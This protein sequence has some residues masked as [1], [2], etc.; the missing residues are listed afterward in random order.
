MR[1]ESNKWHCI[2]M[3]GRERCL[4]SAT[5][6]RQGHHVQKHARKIA[7][8]RRH[9]VRRNRGR[10]GYEC[11]C[12]RMRH[13]SNSPTSLVQV[14]AGTKGASIDMPLT[15]CVTAATT[16]SSPVTTFT[17]GASRA[18]IGVA[19]DRQG[20]G[21][22]RQSHFEVGSWHPQ[23][24]NTTRPS[25]LLQRLFQVH[26]T[27]SMPSPLSNQPTSGTPMSSTL[28]ACI[29]SHMNSKAFSMKD[30]L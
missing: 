3:H 24:V 2:S 17:A 8:R 29:C 19:P 10:D 26:L 16:S 28:T 20:S 1:R 12:R 4:P 7:A 14:E 22:L 21:G 27:R 30:S 18:N 11:I 13:R 25:F 5:C 6:D 15:E 9:H 23:E